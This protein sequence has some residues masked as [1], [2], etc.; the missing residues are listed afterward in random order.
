MKEEVRPPHPLQL[1][2]PIITLFFSPFGVQAPSNPQ[3]PT[4][5][6]LACPS[7]SSSCIHACPS[8]C[9]S[10][11][12]HACLPSSLIVCECVCIHHEFILVL[13][14]PGPRALPLRAVGHLLATCDHLPRGWSVP[15]SWCREWPFARR[16]SRKSS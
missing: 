16:V 11:C 13:L 5:S 4:N 12:F 15:P 8:S 14:R 1:F 7:C 3:Y 9:P 10:S 2:Q 6:G